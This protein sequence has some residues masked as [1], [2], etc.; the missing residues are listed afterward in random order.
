VKIAQQ[1][2]KQITP[3]A[4]NVKIVPMKIFYLSVLQIVEVN[5]KVWRE[6]IILPIP[7]IQI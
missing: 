7:T 6:E 5:L 2:K 3:T 1:T 4:I